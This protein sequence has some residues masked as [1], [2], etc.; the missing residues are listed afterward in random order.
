MELKRK[1]FQTFPLAIVC[2]FNARIIGPKKHQCFV[3][4]I[5]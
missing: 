2:L 4:Y 3:I 1:E 5:T